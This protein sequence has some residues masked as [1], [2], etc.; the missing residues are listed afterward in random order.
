[1]STETQEPLIDWRHLDE[2]TLRGKPELIIEILK[3]HSGGSVDEL[4]SGVKGNNPNSL[5]EAQKIL[6]MHGANLDTEEICELLQGVA[7]KKIDEK[8]ERNKEEEIAQQSVADKDD[9]TDWT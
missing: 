8:E 2:E 7:V 1:M 6:D 5:K 3:I 9:I 4:I